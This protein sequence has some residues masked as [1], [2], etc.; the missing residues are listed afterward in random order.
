MKHTLSLDSDT[1]SMRSIF[2]A[3]AWVDKKHNSY[4]YS[5]FNVKP[6]EENI[7]NMVGSEPSFQPHLGDND[8]AV[9]RFRF[10]L[11]QHIPLVFCF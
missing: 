7:S 4:Q 11:L 5:N 9:Y 3:I 2:S 8:L 1:S 10:S 6:S